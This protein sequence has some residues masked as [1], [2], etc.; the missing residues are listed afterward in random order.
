MATVLKA[1]D[2]V[3]ITKITWVQFPQKKNNKQTMT[4]TEQLNTLA[5]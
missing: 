2:I 4:H 5:F 1:I 3:I